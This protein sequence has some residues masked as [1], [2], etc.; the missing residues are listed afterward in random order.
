MDTLIFSQAAVFH[1]QQLANHLHYHTG[2]RH[3]LSTTQG[4]I[5]LLIAGASSHAPDVKRCYTAFAMELNERQL[6][7]L[8]GQGIHIDPSDIL[9]PKSAQQAG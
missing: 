6:N 2:M 8:A 7:A 3:K 9:H 1:L 5:N 4:I